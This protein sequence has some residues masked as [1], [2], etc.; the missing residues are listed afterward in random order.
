MKIKCLLLLCCLSM[1]SAYAETSLMTQSDAFDA[2]KTSGSRATVTNAFNNI[3]ATSGAAHVDGYSGSPA[4]TSYWGRNTPFGPVISAGVSKVS[5]CS[6]KPSSDPRIANQCEA[7]LSLQELPSKKPQGL[8]TVTDPL[9]VKGDAIT[10]N[11]ET[12]AGAI[13]GAYSACTTETVSLGKEKTTETC[14]EYSATGTEKCSIGKKVTVDADHLFKCLDSQHV[15]SNANCTIG[16]VITVDADA[17]Y[18]CDKNSLG[19]EFLNCNRT[20]NVNVTWSSSCVAGSWIRLAT[21]ARNSWDYVYLELY[22]DPARNDGYQL[23]RTYAGGLDGACGDWQSATLPINSAPAKWASLAPNWDKV[24][25]TGFPAWHGAG[26]C[27]GNSC[28][29]TFSWGG[30]DP[31]VTGCCDS[32]NRQVPVEYC[33]NNEFG[34][35]LHYCPKTWGFTTSV[36][37]A[38][39]RP[40]NYP[41]VTQAWTN[42]CLALEARAQ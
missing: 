42:N 22:C 16:R 6:G 3:N 10:E 4:E 18:Q 30:S 40:Y 13:T 9:V 34:A 32:A 38:F 39:T 5:R 2:G 29:K 36:T 25:W 20:R 26:S 27:N 37:P 35:A 12:I 41:V 24:C 19:H 11:P 17:N 1:G 31:G 15:Q 23:F 7:I 14:D 28:S 21:I 8:I 33:K